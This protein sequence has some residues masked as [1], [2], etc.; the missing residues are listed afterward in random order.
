MSTRITRDPDGSSG[1]DRRGSGPRQWPLVTASLLLCGLAIP[2]IARGALLADDF[3]NCLRPV[4]WG[5]AP[6]LANSWER[7][8]PVRPARFLEILLT[9]GVCQNLPFGV[10]I[11]VPLALTIAVAWLL[12]ALLRDMALPHPWPEVGGIVWLLQPLGTEAALWPAALHVPLGLALGLSAILLHRRGRPLLGSLAA[13]AAFGSVEQAI[14]VLPLATALLVQPRHRRGATSLTAGTAVVVLLVYALSPG[15]DP[16]L[17]VGLVERAFALFAE[18]SF[19]VLYPALGVGAH[20]IPLAVV[21]AWPVSVALLAAAAA[22]GWLVGPAAPPMPVVRPSRR[23]VLTAVALVAA[24]VLLALLPVVTTVPRQGSPRTFAPIWLILAGGAAFGGPLVRWV[25]P[26]RAVA[27]A[28]AA[29]A[30]LSLAFSVA[31]RLASADFVEHAAQQL[32]ERSADGAVIAV[33]DVPRTVVEPAPRGSFAVHEFLYEGYAR[34]ALAYHTDRQAAFR[35]AGPLWPDR[36]C[37]A[38]DEVDLRVHFDELR[39]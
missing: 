8:G 3:D 21:W 36:D 22:A 39:P 9:T 15:V 16:R 7:L 31:V 20:S 19:Y 38:A 1:P 24:L 28:L 25:P 34:D 11:A 13:L 14:F 6:T 4:D 26:A 33:C 35:L 2:V 32:A 17:D 37:P 5:L 12:R 10:A 18:P 23:Q 30:V 27:G 29:G